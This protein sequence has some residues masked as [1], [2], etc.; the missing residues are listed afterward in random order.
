[1]AEKVDE[2]P[3]NVLTEWT[4]LLMSLQKEYPTKY[5]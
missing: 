3:A 4:M 5:K 2:L 1:M